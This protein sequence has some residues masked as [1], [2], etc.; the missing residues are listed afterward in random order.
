MRSAEGIAPRLAAPILSDLVDVKVCEVDPLT[1]ARLDHQRVPRPL[2]IEGYR[3]IGHRMPHPW[4]GI[5]RHRHRYHVL[6]GPRPKLA[7]AVLLQIT[8]VGREDHLC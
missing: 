6:I 5:V 4:A 7:E 1:L 2:F 8:R 3:V